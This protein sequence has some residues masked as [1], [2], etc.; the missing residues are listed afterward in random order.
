[1]KPRYKSY[2]ALKEEGLCTHCGK[3]PARRG[4]TTCFECAV[5]KSERE[6]QRRVRNSGGIERPLGR[7]RGQYALVRDGIVLLKGDVEECRKYL[8]VTKYTVY[9][10]AASGKPFGCDIKI[11]K[12]KANL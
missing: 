5:Y 10:H 6:H 9:H 1:M 2:Y 8:G 12:R 11:Y 4:K 3:K 7:P